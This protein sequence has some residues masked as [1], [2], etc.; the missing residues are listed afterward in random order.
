MEFHI[1]FRAMI[2]GFSTSQLSILGFVRFLALK[3]R[4]V[5]LSDGFN[6]FPTCQVRVVR[7]YVS[8]PAT[9]SASCSSASSSSASSASS[10]SAG[11]QL[12][13]LDRNGPRWTRTARTRTVSSGSECSPP[14]LN[15]KLSI[16]VFAV[17][18]EQHPLDQSDPC[19]T[20][21]TKSLRSYTR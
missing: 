17:G 4:R 1:A 21:T 6:L 15:C 12:Q 11:P 14:D 16:A 9:S 3:T 18:P 8:W 13:A 2:R 7:F 19:R 10:S 5:N 20:S